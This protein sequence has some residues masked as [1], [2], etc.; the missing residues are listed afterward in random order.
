[1]RRTRTTHRALALAVLVAVVLLATAGAALAVTKTGA[2][3]PGLSVSVAPAGV[4]SVIYGSAETTGYGGNSK[5]SGW[6]TGPSHD[7]TVS[8][9]DLDAG[10]LVATTLAGYDAGTENSDYSFTINNVRY[11]RC[12]RASIAAGPGYSSAET[13]VNLDA[14]AHIHLYANHHS[15]TKGHTVKLT[16]RVWPAASGRI[17]FQYWNT[18]LR[19]WR[20]LHS[21]VHVRQPVAPPSTGE[22]Y[23]LAIYRWTPQHR[24]TYR[25]RAWFIGG[26]YG[27]GLNTHVENYWSHN[28][29]IY[30]H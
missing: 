29:K 17:K 10:A 8:L 6:V 19:A 28:F 13:T 22:P 4:N 20:P 15:I 25:V 30:V 23:T 1:M 18:G 21:D 2:V 11:P 16:A 24:R 5:L 14:R 12:F 26:N 9:Y 7:V 3:R 27:T